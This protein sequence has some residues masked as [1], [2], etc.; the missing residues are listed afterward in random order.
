M[1]EHQIPEGGKIYF[2]EVAKR[3][4]EIENIASQ[5]FYK[6]S[7]QEMVTPLFSYHQI[8]SLPHQQLIHLTDKSN[9][10]MNLRADN[11]I[12]IVKIL[13]KRIGKNSQNSRWF[14]IQPIYRY[15]SVEQYQ[16]GA[17]IIGGGDLG[18]VLNLNIAIFKQLNFFPTLQ[19][20]NVAIPKKISQYLDIPIEVFKN[21]EIG[22][23]L[24]LDI[25]WLNRLLY[26]ENV[27]EIDRIVSL[28]P[29][30]I[31]DEVEKIRQIVK[32]IQWGDIK[33]A[34]LYY[35]KMN[36]YDN[37]IF[38]FIKGNR[39]IS[40]GGNYSIENNHSVGFAIYTDELLSEW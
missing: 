25:E 38:R 27:E 15:P 37:L 24:S 14:Y 7:F 4:R 31:V 40:R 33:I 2:G 18:E 35:S 19:I 11:T 5:L 30:E 13:L 17:E 32:T 39:T 9:N 20:S 8:S 22:K 12:D 6:N 1:F 36:Y 23:I 26:L 10:L 16:I 3:K 28:V 29:N 34:P 21:I